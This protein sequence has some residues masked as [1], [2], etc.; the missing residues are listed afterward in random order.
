MPRSS[1]SSRRNPTFVI[2]EKDGHAG[3]VADDADPRRLA[4]PGVGEARARRRQML[5]NH[6]HVAEHRHEVRVAG[7]ARHD[8]QV[9]VVGD[10]RT[11]D[12]ADVPAEVV[13][14]GPVRRGERVEA[15][16]AE[17]VDLERLARRRGR[18]SS[19]R[20]GTARR[21][22]GL[23]STGTCSAARTRARRDA[24]RAAL[25][26]RR[27][28]QPCRRSSRP[29]CPRSGRTRAARAPTAAPPR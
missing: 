17:P 2:V 29:A 5:G 7:P 8:V 20:A 4:R 27:R 25:H 18:R 14:L 11:G 1:W 3:I 23:T 15:L 13:A 24:R 21:A 28:L 22:G 19:R 9:T 12:A 16:R 6:L 26:R 10:P